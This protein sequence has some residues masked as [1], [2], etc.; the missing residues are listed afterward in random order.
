M[1]ILHVVTSLFATGGGTSEVIP[2]MCEELVSAGHEV[3]I[4]TGRGG[5]PSA[6]TT[7]AINAGVDVR[8]CPMHLVP[9]IGF[10]RLTSAYMSELKSGVSWADVV[11][12]HGLWQDP[13]WYAPYLARKFGKPYVMQ[14]HGFLEPERLK[15]SAFQKK[16]IGAL[17]ERPNLN[18]A[19]AIISTAESEKIGIEK[20]KVKSPVFVVPLGMDTSTLDAATR[21]VSSLRVYGLN[22]QKKTLLFFSRLTP[23]KGLDMLAEAWTEL[24]DLHGRWQLFIV[25]PDDRGYTKVIKE[26]FNGKVDDGSVVF[27]G[28]IYGDEKSVLLKSVDAFVL[29][30]RSENFS[31]AVQEALAAGLPVVCTKGAPWKV[32]ADQGAGEWVDVDADSIRDGL[33][34]VLISGADR[35]R[36]MGEAGKRIVARDFKWSCVTA[37]LE[38]VYWKAI[39]AAH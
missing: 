38:D 28:P 9:H 17:I 13:V 5:E 4:V 33:R 20:Y 19:D 39:L 26:Y 30:T 14:P 32:I 25:G 16:I 1:K 6:A 34:H 36:V 8:F 15:K 23:I 2:R 37:R 10:W 27:S 21:D 29:P 24:N 22:P 3:R 31:I 35:L 12:V 7:R 18:G 11:H